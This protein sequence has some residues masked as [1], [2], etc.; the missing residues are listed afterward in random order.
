MH[1]PF[2]DLH[3]FRCQQK[4]ARNFPGRKWIWLGFTFPSCLERFPLHYER[5]NTDLIT[6]SLPNVQTA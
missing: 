6:P 3:V 1:N 2:E 5:Q 4:S